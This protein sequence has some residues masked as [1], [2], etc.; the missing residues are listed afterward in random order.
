MK[1]LLKVTTGTRKESAWIKMIRTSYLSKLCLLT[2]SILTS[3]YIPQSWAAVDCTRKT[4]SVTFD[5]GTITVQRDTANMTVLT[6]EKTSAISGY[7]CSNRPGATS[8]GIRSNGYYVS[9]IHATKRIYG[10]R[11]SGIGYVMG[12]T[13]GSRATMWLGNSQSGWNGTGGIFATD[14]ALAAA[15]K[16]GEDFPMTAKVQLVKIGATA[17][18]PL[19]GTLGV[20]FA[21]NGAPPTDWGSDIPIYIIGNINALS[22]SLDSTSINVPLGNISNTKFTGIATTAG[23]KSFNVGL[24]CDKDAKINVSLDGTQNADTSQT[25][26]LALTSA[27]QA[28]IATGVGVQLLYG[29]APLEIKKSILLKTS[30]GGQET[31]P[32]TARYYQTKVVVGAG[33]AN[34]SATLNITYQ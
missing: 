15:S 34:S 4:T 12:A 18:G 22:C 28:G 33:Q 29:G 6:P 5:V 24:T 8:V 9:N 20:F 16:R 2:G 31:L 7:D 27:G 32:F 3:L 14:W 23:D 30:A 19:N 13:S 21:G 11:L 17:S 1:E 26:V 25:S 10:S